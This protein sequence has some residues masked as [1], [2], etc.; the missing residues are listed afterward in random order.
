MFRCLKP[1]CPLE[2]GTRKHP[3]CASRMLCR[4]LFLA[5]AAVLVLSLAI[6]FRC[7]NEAVRSTSK[8]ESAP[9]ACP[10]AVHLVS[11]AQ[12][13][14]RERILSDLHGK[15]AIPADEPVQVPQQR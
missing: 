10:E 6:G 2:R 9:F 11:E 1:V 5:L 3:G 15:P 4:A 13:Y 12:D 14:A 8:S 7:L